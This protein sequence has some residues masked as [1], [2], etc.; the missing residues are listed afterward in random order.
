MNRLFVK[1]DRACDDKT[2]IFVCNWL[3]EES[4]CFVCFHAAFHL[5]NRCMYVLQ[6]YILT[7]FLAI[8]RSPSLHIVHQVLS[9]HIMLNYTQIAILDKT[10]NKLSSTHINPRH[11]FQMTK[12]FLPPPS[13]SHKQML[14]CTLIFSVPQRPTLPRQG[15]GSVNPSTSP[16]VMS[17]IFYE[18]ENSHLFLSKIAVKNQRKV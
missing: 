18:R 13:C 15:W 10:F 8:T 2:R 1:S 4:S 6:A 5:F 3:R 12:T 14:T 7:S 17:K 11:T 16:V 9:N